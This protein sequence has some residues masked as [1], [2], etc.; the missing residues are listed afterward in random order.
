[1]EFALV[2]LPFFMLTFA[3]LEIGL[4]FMLS[5]VLDSA[6]TGAGRIVRTGQAEE[7]GVTA[8]QFKTEFCSRMSVFAADCDSRASIDVR[9]VVQF[10]TPLAP[11][12]VQ[13]GV[14]N[15]SLLTYQTGQPG[16][17][18]LIRVWYRHPVIT[19]FLQQAL[20]RLDDNS[21]LLMSTT[22]F[23]NEPYR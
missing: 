12:P 2:S 10:R 22:S 6:T 17:L 13:S 1:M 8:E 3:I 21:A 18:M 20:S 9:E 4:I 14:F 19:P 11:D 7:A 15:D 23:R 16:S 5:A